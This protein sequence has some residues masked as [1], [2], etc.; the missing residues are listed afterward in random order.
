[1]GHSDPLHRAGL[2]WQLLH[3]VCVCVCM[4]SSSA[5][6]YIKHGLWCHHWQGHLDKAGLRAGFS[7]FVLGA[8]FKWIVSNEWL[9]SN[10]IITFC[11]IDN[12]M[13]QSGR[14]ILFVLFVV[15][16][17]ESQKMLQTLSSFIQVE[18]MWP[19]CELLQFCLDQPIY[20]SS[21]VS[22]LIL[23]VKPVCRTFQRCRF[24]KTFYL[25]IC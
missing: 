14:F 5:Q 20:F 8:F 12:N 4:H 2:W 11:L 15:H 18:V 22:A 23:S 10:Q 9:C 24:S 19:L 6:W 1:M 16:W 13:N 7:P 3:Y 21:V 25:F 17:C